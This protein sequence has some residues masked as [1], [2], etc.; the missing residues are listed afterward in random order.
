MRYMGIDYGSKR[1]GIAL[2]DES[3]QFA[4]PHG[5]LQNT[6]NVVAEIKK[7]C[8]EKDVGEVVV[9]ESKNFAQQENDIMVDIRR[10]VEE[11]KKNTVYP[12]HLHPEFLTSAEATQIQG[13]TRMLDAS[14]AA[15]ILKSYLDTHIQNHDH[16]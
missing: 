2:S 16:N 7:I 5:V 1:I 13:E 3:H 8:E 4:F 11:L 6:E 12:I 9:G 10:F 14:A 15:L